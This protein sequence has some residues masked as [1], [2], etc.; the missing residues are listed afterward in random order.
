[1]IA[2]SL[3]SCFVVGVVGAEG[4]G[5]ISK[6]SY[7]DKG[8]DRKLLK[9]NKLHHRDD[10]YDIISNNNSSNNSSS[11]SSSSRNQNE[12]HK[13]KPGGQGS[14]GVKG[15]V[16]TPQSLSAAKG[17]KGSVDN[18]NSNNGNPQQLDEDVQPGDRDHVPRKL[19]KKVVFDAWHVSTG[20]FILAGTYHYHYCKLCLANKHI[21]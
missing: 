6:P 7:L 14:P 9:H 15:K 17:V 20:R 8:L 10:E 18:N 1:M 2:P 5:Q 19:P 16:S 12:E 21:G 11:S 13:A 3:I 4:K